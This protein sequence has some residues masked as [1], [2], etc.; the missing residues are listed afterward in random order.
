M[1]PLKIPKS[2]KTR[3]LKVWCGRCRTE[4]TDVC[5][6]S[7]LPLNK[8]KNGAEHIFR[9]VVYVPGSSERKV[10]QIKDRDIETAI[11]ETALFR[12]QV[13]SGGNFKQPE[14]KN[15]QPE[16]R[17]GLKLVDAMTMFLSFL[18]GKRGPAHTIKIRGKEHVKDIETGLV[19]FSQAMKAKGYDPKEISVEEISQ[20][21]VGYYHLFLLEEKKYSGYSYDRHM[22]HFNGLFNYLK[23]Y[24]GYKDLANPFETVQKR[25]IAPA[26]N[27]TI[28]A[29]EFKKLLEIIT[30]ERGVQT[31]SDG[32]TKKYHYHDFLPSA[33]KL[34]L[35]S[36]LRRESLATLSFDMI[37][38]NSDG[39]PILIRAENLK[40][41]RIMG[42]T[43]DGQKRFTPVPV[44]P[45]LRDLLMNELNYLLYR[46]SDKYILAPESKLERKTIMSILSRSFAHFWQQLDIPDKKDISFKVF[47]KS[48]ATRMVMAAGNSANILTG[49][50][51][52]QN[53]LEKHYTDKEAIARQVAG[54]TEIFKDMDFTQE[55]MRKKELQAVRENRKGQNI[56]LEK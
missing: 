26:V 19:L 7:G 43:D 12:E 5:K 24:E 41:N 6:L 13:K 25:K 34:A 28:R 16:K 27:H 10:L 46:K 8:C 22:S 20:E 54:N 32:K 50:S 51:A 53:T 44:T 38:E 33:F 9:A 15:I 29:E 30:P 21:M 40:V 35:L 31:L 2:K 14:I 48:Y 17:K 42:I 45:Q 18:Q 1:K 36:G 52:K 23:K 56:S 3:S 47:R 49:H 55:E 4:V 37:E 39:E 11:K